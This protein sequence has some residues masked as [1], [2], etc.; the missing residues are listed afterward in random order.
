MTMTYAAVPALR[1]EQAVADVWVPRIAAGR[2]DPAF[3][4][5]AEKAALQIV[6]ATKKNLPEAWLAAAR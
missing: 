1:A 4:P 6:A 3:R 5:A 2:Y